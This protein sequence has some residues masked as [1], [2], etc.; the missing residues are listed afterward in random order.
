MGVICPALLILFIFVSVFVLRIITQNKIKAEKLIPGLMTFVS[1]KEGDRFWFWVVVDRFYFKIKNNEHHIPS[2]K[3]K[4]ISCHN[5][6]ASWCIVIII[7]VTIILSFSFFVSESFTE[8]E[9]AD[10]CAQALTK[11]N[12]FDCFDS[13]WTFVDCNEANVSDHTRLTCYRFLTVEDNSDYLRALIQALFIYIACDKF[14][15]VLFRLVTALYSFRKT[16]LWGIIIVTAGVIMLIISIGSTFVFLL[17]RN[18]N[19][20]LS[21]V[22]FFIISLDIFLAGLLMTVG[23]PYEQVEHKK[24]AKL[25][26]RGLTTNTPSE[27]E[28]ALDSPSSLS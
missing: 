7:S 21:N 2:R 13:R 6:V 28:K 25:L 19:N 18:D 10:T 16:K 15:S 1:F 17:V 14:L 12:G 5:N 8:S 3:K 11:P 22:Q 9:S 27:V 26:L 24:P 4:I 20:I 23:M